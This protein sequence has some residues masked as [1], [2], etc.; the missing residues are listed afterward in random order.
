MA[1]GSQKH[2]ELKNPAPSS[3]ARHPR[4]PDHRDVREYAS[5]MRMYVWVPWKESSLGVEVGV[6]IAVATSRTAGA[7][8]GAQ[9]PKEFGS[10]R[11]VKIYEASSQLIMELRMRTEEA[12]RLLHAVVTILRYLPTRLLHLSQVC[13]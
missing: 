12:G 3:Y 9:M 10:S 2:N 1:H 11:Q 8:R 5:A 13:V 6:A 7:T 4:I